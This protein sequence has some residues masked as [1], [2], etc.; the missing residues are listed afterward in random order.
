MENQDTSFFAK[1]ISP[2]LQAAAGLGVM[3]IFMILG[4]IA[5]ANFTFP[6][7]TA[8]AAL[9]MFSVFNSVNSFTTDDMLTYF[10]DSIFSYMALVG[11]GATLAY[12]F[13]SVSINEAGTFRWI[14]FT[15]TFS[16]FGFIG[17][18]SF[19]R[20]ILGALDNEQKK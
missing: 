18:A 1:S 3:L 20:F 2:Y 4:K 13:S 19:I 11:L 15:I 16:Y 8:G 10:R 17:I 9:L 5:G 7:T 6:W 14:Y 12:L